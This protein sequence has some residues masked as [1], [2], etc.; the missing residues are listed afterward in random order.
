MSE[1]IWTV[2][3]KPPEAGVQPVNASTAEI[4]D[5]YLVLLHGD[6]TLSALFLLSVVGSWSCEQAS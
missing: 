2:R 4:A 6:G 3:F 5:D 1:K